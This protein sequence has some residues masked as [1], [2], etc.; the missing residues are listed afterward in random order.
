MTAA[1]SED[2]SWQHGKQQAVAVSDQAWWNIWGKPHSTKPLS[3]EWLQHLEALPAYPQYT[4]LTAQ[5]LGNVLRT[6]SAGKAAGPDGWRVRELKMWK[7]PLLDWTAELLAMVETTGRWPTELTRA[8]TVLL[9]KGGTDDPLDKRPITLLP[10]LYRVWAALRATQMR[11]WMRSAS[12]PSLVHGSRGTMAGAEH[13]G[14]LLGMELEEARAFEDNLA[15]VAVD[16]SKCY[17]HLGLDYVQDTLLA[18]GVSGW[19]SGPLLAMYRAPRHIKV[20][21]AIGAAR[22]PVR[23]IPPGCPAAVDILMGGRPDLVG[24]RRP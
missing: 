14:L 4:R 16:W 17:D 12:I 1:L 21:G 6:Y 18:A 24:Q 2:G 11:K 7:G 10:M 3:R 13:Q 5:Q 15:G 22:T 23:C 9:P 8:E 19:V 20:D